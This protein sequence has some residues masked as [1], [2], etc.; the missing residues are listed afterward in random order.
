MCFA[1]PIGWRWNERAFRPQ[2]E[3][4]TPAAIEELRF[5]YPNIR[6]SQP[7]LTRRQGP[8]NRGRFTEPNAG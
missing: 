8:Q 7:A 2:N 6:D 4:K 1:F 5:S 3:A